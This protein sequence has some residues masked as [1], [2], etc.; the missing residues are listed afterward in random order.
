M[1][2]A[3]F[4]PETL[5]MLGE[6]F[7]E[8]WASVAADFATDP[9][10]I[11]T[12]RFRLATIILS[13]AKDGQLGTLQISRTAGRLIRQAHARTK[14]SCW[15]PGCAGCDN[16]STNVGTAAFRFDFV[17]RWRDQSVQSRPYDQLHP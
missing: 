7:D 8:V 12:S 2:N 1:S 3:S 11:G 9:D 10:Q 13:L 4:A 6:V 16:Q 5:Q 17:C 15:G 14:Q